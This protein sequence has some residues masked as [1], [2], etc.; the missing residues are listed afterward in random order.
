MS[1]INTASKF[2]DLHDY[3]GQSKE[4]HKSHNNVIKADSYNSVPNDSINSIDRTGCYIAKHDSPKHPSTWG[5]VYDRRQ[6]LRNICSTKRSAPA[7]SSKY[8]LAVKP[9]SYPLLP[10]KLLEKRP[11]HVSPQL[12]QGRTPQGE[13]IDNLREELYG[14]KRNYA[15]VLKENVILKTR[16]KRSSN[17]IIR[18]DRQLQN[19]LFIQSKGYAS[20][21]QRGNMLTMKQKIV[22]LESLLKEKTNEISRLKHDR[23]AMMISGNLEHIAGLQAECKHCLT[24]FTPP[25]SKIRADDVRGLTKRQTVPESNN[26]RKLKQ[27]VSFLEK[28][29]DKMRSKL[30]IFFNCSSCSPNKLST[31]E[32][33]ELIALIIHLKNELGKKERWSNVKNGQSRQKDISLMYHRK[34]LPVKQKSGKSTN[35]LRIK[36]A[37]VTKSQKIATRVEESESNANDWESDDSRART[38]HGIAVNTKTENVTERLEYSFSGTESVSEQAGRE[39]EIA[40]Q[41]Q[42]LVKTQTEHAPETTQRNREKQK[43]SEDRAD[44]HAIV[45]TS[46]ER[47][48]LEDNQDEYKEISEDT[49]SSQFIKR[50]SNDCSEV[51]EWTEEEKFSSD[52]QQELGKIT[53]VKKIEIQGDEIGVGNAERF[54]LKKDKVMPNFVSRSVL[55]ITSAHLKR[56]ELLS[57]KNN[58]YSSSA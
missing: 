47:S 53:P 13:L 31:F 29:N 41:R 1:T 6:M 43:D 49:A 20:D 28:E 54:G 7:T 27:A 24:Y 36:K 46:T 52:A 32:R 18:K 39:S 17:E 2:V 23:E 3:Q 30:R 21:D 50:N 35:R 12:D 38:P 8:C 19:L 55:R 14:I 45:D 48:T 22:M 16:L 58:S 4:K 44:I 42:Q 9:S 25:P 10:L 26:A 5:E 11:L 33:E 40:E 34:L 51:Q 37:K 57:T 56:L 15:A